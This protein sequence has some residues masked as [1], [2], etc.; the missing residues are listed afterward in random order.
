MQ[1]L[2]TCCLT[3]RSSLRPD[4]VAGVSR[5]SYMNITVSIALYAVVCKEL[6][7]PLRCAV[8]EP[9]DADHQLQSCGIPG[10]VVGARRGV[11]VDYTPDA[12]CCCCQVLCCTCPTASLPTMHG[13]LFPLCLLLIE[14][15]CTKQRQ[16]LQ[17]HC[18]SGVYVVME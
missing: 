10:L 9:C 7:L 2:P 6:G 13:I 18:I 15:L 8:Y 17:L 12:S 5:G 3:C 14:C 4:P 11:L 1:N 16:T